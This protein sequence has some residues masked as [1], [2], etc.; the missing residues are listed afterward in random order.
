MLASDDDDNDQPR[1]NHLHHKTETQVGDTVRVTI[2]R[3]GE[4]QNVQVTLAERP[5]TAVVS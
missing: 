4:E 1:E 5:Q 3:D 2:I